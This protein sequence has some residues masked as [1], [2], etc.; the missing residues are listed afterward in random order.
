MTDSST[1]ALNRREPTPNRL[2]LH[3]GSVLGTEIRAD[4]SLLIVFALIL[5]DLGAGVLPRWHPEWSA[6]FVWVMAFAAATLFFLSVLAHEMSHALVGRAQ[7]MSVR[8]I[9]LF[10]FG[11]A[12]ELE[13]EPSSPKAE[14]WMAI[15]GPVTSLAIG[16]A[17]TALGVAL[18]QDVILPSGGDIP[19]QTLSQLAPVPTLL[20]W[21][22]PINVLLAVFNVLPGFPL[23]GGR[24]LRSVLWAVTKDFTRAT[25]WAAGVGRAFGWTLIALGAL[26]VFAGGGVQGLWL[27][28]IGWFLSAAARTSRERAV[29]GKLLENVSVSDVMRT[30][31]ATVGPNT[32]VESLV[33][34]VLL[35]SDQECIPV[36]AP[37]GDRGWSVFRTR[38]ACRWIAGKRFRF[39]M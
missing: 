6:P 38:A 1:H 39:A 33:N 34:E 31:I 10:L 17:A 23:D 27:V 36:L 32:T 26:Q 35:V 25:T 18:A 16:V 24:V 30:R 4:W 19:E 5:F 21:L 28:L 29:A 11:G 12:A 9:T 7:G 22:G 14:F 2:G 13:G 8:R 3:L 20:L 37:D 15:V